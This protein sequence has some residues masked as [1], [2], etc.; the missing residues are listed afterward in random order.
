M[1]PARFNL[2]SLRLLLA[3]LAVSCSTERDSARP[4]SLDAQSS[5]VDSAHP[6]PAVTL[7]VVANDFAFDAVSRID[8]G[9]VTLRIVNRGALAHHAALFAL[10]DPG[11]LDAFFSALREGNPVPA[12]VRAV[13]ATRNAE[14]G[15]ASSV[16]LV[17]EPGEYLIVCLDTGAGG[18]RH[19]MLGMVRSLRV[20]SSRTPGPAAV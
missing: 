9:A 1:A 14:P 17:L 7:E 2:L 10:D 8:A 4:A 15:R 5:P 16:T 3:A 13:G 19:V 6:R 18:Q 20:A 11:A 12:M